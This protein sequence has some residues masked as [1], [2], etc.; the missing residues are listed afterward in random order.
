MHLREL[1][2]EMN[3]FVTVKGWYRADS[4]R[5][6]T[7]R[8]LA[9]SLSLEANEVL[10]HFQWREGAPGEL[11]GGAGL[12]TGGRGPVPA[13]N[14]EHRRDR[15]GIGDPRQT[16]RQLW[17]HLGLTGR[18]NPGALA[19]I[20]DPSPAGEGRKAARWKGLDSSSPVGEGRG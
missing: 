17:A 1:T 19:L 3:Q 10:E 4:P 14:G 18:D 9:I 8:N 5:P 7:P 6:Q 12:R 11:T 13:A 2:E 20:P 15:S 16:A